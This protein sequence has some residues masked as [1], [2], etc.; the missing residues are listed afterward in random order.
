VAGKRDQENARLRAELEAVEA[1]RLRLRS[2]LEQ[3]RRSPLGPLIEPARTIRA[4]LERRLQRFRGRR[5][6]A[7][8]RA[9]SGE[10]RRLPPRLSGSELAWLARRRL[11]PARRGVPVVPTPAREGWLTPILVDCFGRDGST[12]LM[13]MLASSPAIAADPKYPY[14]RRYFTYLWRWSRLPSRTEWPGALWSKDDVVSISQEDDGA[15]LGPPPWLPR[16]LLDERG[17][18]SEFARR[19][20]DAAWGELSGRAIESAAAAGGPPPRYYAEKHANTWMV[21]LRELPPVRVIALLRDPRDVHA[22]ILAFEDRE[23]AT[24]FAILDARAGGDRMAGIV[25]RHRRRLRWIAELIER[26][27]APVVRYEELAADPAAVARALAAE[28]EVEIEPGDPELESLASRHGS[29]DDGGAGRWRSDLDPAIAERLT[30]ELKPE[31]R[32]LGFEA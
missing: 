1:E 24:S 12:A 26:D 14:E 22:S 25:D 15:L 16:E 4:A 5:G 9:E 17:D 3:I 19:A 31:L 13:A 18:G 10:A 6:A 21:D 27:A 2:E 28:L 20:F 23:P 11:W 29:S 7:G 30:D 32:A 8:G